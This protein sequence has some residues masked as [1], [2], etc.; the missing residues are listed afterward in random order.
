MR[1]EL[2]HSGEGLVAVFAFE[3]GGVV[4]AGGLAG[5]LDDGVG[6]GAEVFAPVGVGGRAAGGGDHDQA[7]AFVEV[8]QQDAAGQAAAAA[9]RGEAQD[10][11]AHEASA[12]EGE[13]DVLDAGDRAHQSVVHRR[14]CSL[15]GV[16]SA[17]N[18]T[19]T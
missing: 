1:E 8:E 4:F 12:E 9:C 5:P 17:R 18:I 15:R 19:E 2:A 11:R 7:G 14:S 3:L 10:G 16:T 13:L 6:G